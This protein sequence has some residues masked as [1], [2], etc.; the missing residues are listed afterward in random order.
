[1]GGRRRRRRRKKKRTDENRKEEMGKMMMKQ[2]KNMNGR[3]D[4]RDSSI[5]QEGRDDT[6]HEKN[7][8]ES[9]IEED[10]YY[11]QPKFL[12]LM[13]FK[14]E[15]KLKLAKELIVGSQLTVALQNYY[16]NMATTTINE[17]VNENDVQSVESLWEN[18]RFIQIEVSSIKML[19]LF[20][21]VLSDL[22]LGFPL[23]YKQFSH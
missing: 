8:Q 20:F 6:S 13:T 7:E 16:T 18:I 4:K 10:G 22:A 12:S 23:T 17:K 21:Q 11:F 2:H 15:A 5:S 19:D 1:M 3:H 9:E 14:K